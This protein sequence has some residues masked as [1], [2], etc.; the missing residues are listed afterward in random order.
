MER[1]AYLRR[2]RYAGDLK[3]SAET[4][5]A[6]HLAHLYAV[7]FENLDIHLGRPIVLEMGRLFDKIVRRRRGGFCYELN[8]LFAALLLELGFEVVYLSAS[9]AHEDGSFG[10]EFDHL[11]LQVR[12]PDQPS[13]NWL[14]DVGWGDTFRQPLRLEESG[15]QVQQ[16]GTYWLE[17]QSGHQ[18]LWQR[19]ASGR[20]ER[21]YRFSLQPRSFEQFEPMCRYHQTSP[22]SLFTR[23]RLC[24]LARPDGRITL[25]AAR[26]ITTVHGRR[27]ERLVQDETEYRQLLRTQLGIYL[28]DTDRFLSPTG[29]A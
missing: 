6:L 21:Q 7:P 23:K 8:G 16:A 20:V 12:S 5:R 28:A 17:P 25:D 11:V 26:L 2:I 9:D 27:E 24:T 18:L 1:S 13:M 22:D 15:E 3:P 29:K 14:A 19:D 4:L 10:P